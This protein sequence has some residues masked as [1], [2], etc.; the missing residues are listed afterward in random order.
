MA[1]TRK[2]TVKSLVFG[3]LVAAAFTI[4]CMLA[5]AAALVYSRMPDGTLR[6]INQLIKYSAVFL[7][8]SAAVP[9]GGD[10]GL[11]TGVVLA[12]LYIILGYAMYLLLGGGSFD[13][14]C[15]LGELLLGSAVGAVTG[16][17]RANLHPK[18]RRSAA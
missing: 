13:I 14:G 10:K 18:R 15:M 1:R 7:G 4:G 11:I 12:L 17:V 5:L 8:V 3:L 16:A 2:N 9:R 6:L